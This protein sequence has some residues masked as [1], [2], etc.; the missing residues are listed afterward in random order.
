MQHSSF[1]GYYM[2]QGKARSVCIFARFSLAC[3]LMEMENT[4]MQDLEENII[5]IPMEDPLLHTTE[6]PFCYH[7]LCLCHE[8][9]DLIA[10]VNQA[11]T[12][13]LLTT[14]QPTLTV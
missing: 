6:H 2:L 1:T 11:V 10:P 8:D 3:Q 12:D 14:A 5:I 4:I 13:R 7:D 9:P